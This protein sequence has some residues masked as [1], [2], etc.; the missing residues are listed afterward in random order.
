MFPG[1]LSVGAATAASGPSLHEWAVERGLRMAADGFSIGPAGRGL[2]AT[3]FLP[4]RLLGE[5]LSWF[6]ARVKR[7]LPDH[8]RLLE[9]RREAV[10]IDTGQAGGLVI[11]LADGTGVGADFAF[12]TTGYTP[13]ASTAAERLIAEPYP[14]PERL[15]PIAPGQTVAVGGFGLSAMDVLSGLTRGARRPVPSATRARS[16]Y[17]PSGGEPSIV[18]YSRSGVPCRA[19]PLVTRFEI[20]YDPLVF[21]PASVDALRDRRGGRARRSISTPTSCR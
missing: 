6:Y 8:V 2:K 13:N 19:R 20:S 1:P 5:Y 3:D 21:T 14:L 7:Q 15:E 4:R 10:D 16:E 9:H 11:T 17:E 12:L 18:M